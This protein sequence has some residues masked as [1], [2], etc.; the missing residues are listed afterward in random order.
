M[1][2]KVNDAARPPSILILFL[3]ATASFVRYKKVSKKNI[4]RQEK[5]DS[6]GEY[7]LIEKKACYLIKKKPL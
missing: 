7:P 2:K 5:I 4:F 6:S 1:N 3:I